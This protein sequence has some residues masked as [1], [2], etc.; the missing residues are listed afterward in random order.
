MAETHP[1]G[2]SDFSDAEIERLRLRL[3][4]YA[5]RMTEGQLMALTDTLH[6]ALRRRRGART[7]HRTDMR[8]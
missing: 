5:G 3:S 2:P 7:F 1:Y 4:Q 6:D 8:V